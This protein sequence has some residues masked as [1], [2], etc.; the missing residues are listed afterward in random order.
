MQNY[1]TKI[2]KSE[3]HTM[4]RIYIESE[5]QHVLSRQICKC[6]KFRALLITYLDY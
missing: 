1:A 2:F 6:L 5:F 3:T 4:N